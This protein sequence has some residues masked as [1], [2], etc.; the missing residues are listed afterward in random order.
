MG[1]H[2]D[3]DTVDSGCGLDSDSKATLERVK[4]STRD[5]YVKVSII[6]LGV[7]VLLHVFIY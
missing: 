7:S 2:S 4:T 5:E 6:H 1:G 3:N